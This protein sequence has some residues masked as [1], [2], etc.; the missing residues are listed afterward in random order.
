MALLKGPHMSTVFFRSK[1]KGKRADKAVVGVL[2][3]VEDSL[4]TLG[5]IRGLLCA[6]L[7]REGLSV[8]CGPYPAHSVTQVPHASSRGS[9]AGVVRDLYAP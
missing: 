5:V 6:M 7:S 8:R 3:S 1:K 4:V 9:L 2:V